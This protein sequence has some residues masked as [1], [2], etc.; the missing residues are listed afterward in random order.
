[1]KAEEVRARS[2]FF[3]EELLAESRPSEDHHSPPPA[4]AVTDD[5]YV[6]RP[7]LSGGGTS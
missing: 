3:D 1:M 5:V 6:D 4:S 2:R 7:G